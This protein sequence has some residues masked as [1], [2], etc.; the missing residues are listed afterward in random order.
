MQVYVNFITKTWTQL[1]RGHWKALRNIILTKSGYSKCFSASNLAY[2]PQILRQ[3]CRN[4][5]FQAS[6]TPGQFLPSVS[7]KYF[8]SWILSIY[9]GGI[10]SDFLLISYFWRLSCISN[11]KKKF[12]IVKTHMEEK[13]TLL[14]IKQASLSLEPVGPYYLLRIIWFL[15]C[16]TRE[17][18]PWKAK[19][20]LACNDC[21]LCH[22]WDCGN[23][24]S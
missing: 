4:H 13:V 1:T 11:V 10:L 3:V 6:P 8:I 14:I 18:T 22:L 21:F 15:S 9:V 20:P 17:L 16:T 2:L 12:S 24:D 7:R 23:H 5:L 19:T